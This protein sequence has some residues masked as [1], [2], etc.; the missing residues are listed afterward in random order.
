MPDTTTP[1]FEAVTPRFPVGDI[2]KTLAFYVEQLGFHVGWK[3]GSP[4]THANV[5]RGNVS[6]DLIQVPDGHQGTAMAYIQMSGVDAY[7][8]ELSLK[9]VA[10]T[11]VDNRPYG[12]RDFE[13]VDPSGNRI[14]FGQPLEP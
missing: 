14:A 8:A 13:V 7:F 11:A 1:R 10:A 12:M 4:P 6:L 2:E 3:W 5:C 9:S